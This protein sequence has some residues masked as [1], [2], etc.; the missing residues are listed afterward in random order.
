MY[1][2]V[3]TLIWGIANS[4]LWSLN[5]GTL[6]QRSEMV[7]VLARRKC[8]HGNELIWHKLLM[9][10]EHRSTINHLLCKCKVSQTD[11]TRP[12]Y[13]RWLNASCFEILL[14]P[15]FPRVMRGGRNSNVRPSTDGRT[16]PNSYC[17]AVGPES[18]RNSKDVRRLKVVNDTRSHDRHKDATSFQNDRQ[19]CTEPNNALAIA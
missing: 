13:E 1:E 9:N 7:P 15:Y 17:K 3:Q 11:K 18:R 12:S 6:K 19:H 5:V 10:I 4:G 16:Q 2:K 8:V 14:P